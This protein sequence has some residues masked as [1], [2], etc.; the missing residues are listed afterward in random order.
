MFVVPAY[1]VPFRLMISGYGMAWSMFNLAIRWAIVL[2]IRE[3]EVCLRGDN[4]FPKLCLS[5]PCMSST[6]D[7]TVGQYAPLVRRLALQLAARLPPSVELDDLIQA[8]MMGLL[9]AVRRYR[10]TPGAQFDTYAVARIRGAMLDELRAQDWLPRSV[11]SKSRQIEQAMSALSQ[12]LGRPP[13]ETETAQALGLSLHE[14]Q[15]LLEEAQGAQ[16]IRYEDLTRQGQDADHA[17]DVAATDGPA[18]DEQWQDNPL[19]QLISKGLRTALVASIAALP[20]REALLLSLQFEQ[21]LNQRE[22]AGVMGLTE[23]RVSQ[24]RSQAVARIR[25]SLATRDWH[26]RPEEAALHSIV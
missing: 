23:G 5:C 3:T 26:E 11:R 25:A 13:T 18:G 14:Y 19:N 12:S 16:I 24:I 20:E 17:L 2:Q 1:L 10:E 4:R 21:D 22:I 9:D 8:G 7:L 6:E 15:T